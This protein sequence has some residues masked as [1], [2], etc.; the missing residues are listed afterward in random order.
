MMMTVRLWLNCLPKLSNQK[1][2]VITQMRVKRLM[3]NKMETKQ[4]TIM[5]TVLHL[6][7]K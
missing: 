4:L 7:V 1:R 5:I 6:N 2:T 3:K